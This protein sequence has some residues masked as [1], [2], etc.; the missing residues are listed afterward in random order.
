MKSG[1]GD[2]LLRFDFG[3]V[4]V[5]GG[6]VRLESALADVLGQHRITGAVGGGGECECGHRGLRE[7]LD[8]EALEQIRTYRG[9][10]CRDLS[11]DVVRIQRGAVDQFQRP[12]PDAKV[13]FGAAPFGTPIDQRVQAHVGKRAQDVGEDL[14]GVHGRRIA[15]RYTVPMMRLVDSSLR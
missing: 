14:N 2:S 11:G 5:R 15:G 13:W 10:Q 8:R 12:G 9:A 3:D 1:D 4:P 6:I 7:R